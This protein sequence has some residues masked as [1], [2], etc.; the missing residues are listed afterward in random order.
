MPLAQ[1]LFVALL[2]SAT[3]TI[4]IPDQWPKSL[5]ECGMFILAGFLVCQG[6]VSR[7]AVTPAIVLLVPVLAGFAQLALGL[8]VDRAATVQDLLHWASLG[9]TAFIASVLA[10]RRGGRSSMAFSLAV[11]G[12]SVAIFALL[13][14]YTSE[15]RIFWQWPS[16]EPKVFGPFHSRNNFASFVCV[17]LPLTLWYSSG[18]RG[19]SGFW[20]SVSVLLVA[21]VVTSGSRAGVTLVAVEVAAFVLY[22]LAADRR[23]V[24]FWRALA[25]SLAIAVGAAVVGW[26]TLADKLRQDD[27]LRY[28]REIALSAAEMIASRPVAG[29]GLGAF[30]AAYPAHALFDTGRFVNYAHNE[31]LEFAAEG[32]IGLATYLALAALWMSRFVFRHPWAVGLPVLCVHALVDYPFQ[33]TGV[34]AWLVAIVALLALSA[35]NPRYG[36]APHL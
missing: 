34:A 33:R 3:L 25:V 28:R 13:Q 9:A 16:G 1:S 32:G 11:A 35:R 31:W 4:W 15:G 36:H 17:I 27:P 2:L 26:E 24:A 12:G 14:Y 18:T 10:G 7:T 19:I 8:S 6:N 20:T 5:F 29:F 21:G 22:W 30:S 23:D